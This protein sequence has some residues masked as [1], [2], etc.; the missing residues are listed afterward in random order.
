MRDHIFGSAC[1]GRRV[2]HVAVRCY[3]L[4]AHGVSCTLTKVY[5]EIGFLAEGR[6]PS[7]PSPP[8]ILYSSCSAGPPPALFSFLVDVVVVVDV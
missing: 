1:S 3:S 2:E 6:L 5:C 4:C 7:Q 8:W